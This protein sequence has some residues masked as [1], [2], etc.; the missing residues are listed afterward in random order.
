MKVSKNI[1]NWNK[2]VDFHAFGD[3][4]VRQSFDWQCN[5]WRESRLPAGEHPYSLPKWE[6][7]ALEDERER[8]QSAIDAGEDIPGEAT[9]RDA[10]V[11]Y[12]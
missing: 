6:D 10:G 5:A 1:R 2:L 7:Y 3:G 4:W 8:L 12:G 11:I 9:L